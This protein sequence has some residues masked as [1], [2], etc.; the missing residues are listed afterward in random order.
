[1]LRPCNTS[2]PADQNTAFFCLEIVR[3]RESDY[4][5]AESHFMRKMRAFQEY[6]QQKKHEARWGIRV[7]S[8]ARKRERAVNLCR[9]P[10]ESGLAFKRF[11]FTDF[12]RYSIDQTKSAPRVTI[13]SSNSARPS[14][15]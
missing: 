5:K 9:K 15:A 1:M 10:G 12:S 13:M 4:Q 8:V 6:A 2:K 3:A 11:R 14:S 7:V